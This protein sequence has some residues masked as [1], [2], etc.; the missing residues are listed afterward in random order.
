MS[1]SLLV[2]HPAP[3]PTE[4]LVGYVLRL[5]EENGYASPWSVYSLADLKQ[6]EIRTCG[7]N[8]EKLAAII[9]RS[10][11]EL[12]DIRFSAPVNHPR[13]ARLLG[14][15]LVPMDL[16]ILNPGLCPRCVADKGFIEAHWHLT[17]MVGCP[18][19]ECRPALHCPKCGKC[20]RLFRPGLLECACGGNLVDCNLPSLPKADAALLD[21]LRRKVLG[22]PANDENPLSL[23][24]DQLMAMNL[25]SM[26][27]VVRTLG[28]HR[29][30]ADGST[31]LKDERQLLSAAAR[32]LLDWPKNFIILLLD[33]GKI[34]QPS[35]RGGVRRQF[36]PIYGA[37]FK[38]RAVNPSQQTDF[39]RVAFL[40]F[41]ENHW[42]RGY[43]DPKLL[44]QARGK[45]RS[46]FITQAEFAAQL[47]IHVL[48]ASRLLKDR[49][50]PSRRI[51]CGKS[52]RI[53]V[54]FSRNAIPR[55][56]P[57]RIY[58]ERDAAKRTGLSV[59]VLRGLK[60]S[61]IFEFNHLLPTKGGYHELDIDAFTK[62]LLALAPPAGPASGN[63]S[64]YITVKTVMS[65]HHDSPETKV[66]VVGALLARSLAIVGN[67]DGTI[68][69]LLMDRAEYG[70]FVTAFRNRAA[71]DT[72]PSY[73]VEKHLHC[74]A[75]TVPGLLKKGLLEGHRSPT[76]LRITCESVEA[77][78]TKYLS[79][80]SIANSIGTTCTRGLM[81]LSKKN[82]INLLSVP[83]TG[84]RAQQPFIRASDRPKLMEARLS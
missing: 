55:T 64:E 8:L 69:G 4:S 84:R 45:V 70:R 33:V 17:L 61:G 52:E 76:G 19:H 2:R 71:G 29:L 73:I 75:S 72:M 83:R 32:V 51:Q 54:D 60:N 46:R 10:G 24:R 80:A 11:S 44:K 27:H 35:G 6:N 18:V 1:T 20:L 34:L 9:N 39:L 67:S 79:L 50:I 30:I 41:A 36:E 13:W 74:D 57:G 3:Y 82:G 31:S 68:A 63:A 37:L 22:L 43:V 26:L 12:A 7:F 62:R 56:C 65:G 16:N 21:I 40:E 48:T 25:R 47:G 59:G 77:F 14:N 53:L 78:K 81:H 23:P 66:D 15:S 58:M 49:K 42:D 5:A 28:R 38:N